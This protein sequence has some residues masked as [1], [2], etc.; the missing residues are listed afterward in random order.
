MMFIK[1]KVQECDF[2]DRKYDSLVDG[3]G[4]LARGA[5]GR[6]CVVMYAGP[7]YVERAK[8]KTMTPEEVDAWIKNNGREGDWLDF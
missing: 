5:T 2:N 1:M 3:A 4:A 7:E 6:W 8:I